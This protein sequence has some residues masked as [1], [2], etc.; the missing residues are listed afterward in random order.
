MGFW[1]YLKAIFGICF[2]IFAAYY[3]TRYYARMSGG[4]LQRRSHI[5][6]HGST[7]VGRDKALVVVSVGKKAYLLGVGTQSIDCLDS[8]DVSELPADPEPDHNIGK[9]FQSELL[10]RMKRLRK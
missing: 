8:F 10:E 1:S 3:V 7:S 9:S 6:I 2:V 5:K 4:G